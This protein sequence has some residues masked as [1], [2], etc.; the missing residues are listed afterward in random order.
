MGRRG[1]ERRQ[2]SK[3]GV[4]S[5]QEGES[6]GVEGSSP[7]CCNGAGTGSTKQIGNCC[8]RTSPHL[9]PLRQVQL[10]TLR[11]TVRSCGRHPEMK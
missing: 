3:A 4:R 8:P 2:S 7:H 6:V 11:N 1:P 9:D 5:P 10:Q